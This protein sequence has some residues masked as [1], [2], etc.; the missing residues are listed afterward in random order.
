MMGLF[1]GDDAAKN[2]PAERVFETDGVRCRVHALAG[3][4]GLRGG[5]LRCGV[6]WSEC[7][8][9]G[10]CSLPCRKRVWLRRQGIPLTPVLSALLPRVPPDGAAASLPRRLVRQNPV[11]DLP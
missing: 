6:R 2:L 7:C 1:L 10:W 3:R 11:Q 8:G 4:A 5:R 9:S